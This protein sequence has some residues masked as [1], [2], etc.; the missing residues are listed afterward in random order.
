M[1]AFLSVG[2][3]PFLDALLLHHTAHPNSRNCRKFTSAPTLENTGQAQ[4]LKK[5]KLIG[6]FL[7]GVG[8]ARNTAEVE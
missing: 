5:I 7:R 6:L 2:T 8:A 1:H 3:V 4:G